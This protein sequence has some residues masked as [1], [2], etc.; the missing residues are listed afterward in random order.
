MH[1]LVGTDSVHTTAA[2]CDYLVDRAG[3]EDAVTVV[4]VVPSDDPTA[5]RD[6]EEALNVATVRLTG[7]G[8]VETDLREGEPATTLL[9]AADETNADEIVLGPRRGS[10]DATADV[11]STARAV[12]TD[13]EVPVVIVPA[14]EF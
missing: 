7:V 13:A 9:A 3:T 14:P 4:A 8:E 12:L 1:Y 5:T 6:C 10:P 2:V 11:G